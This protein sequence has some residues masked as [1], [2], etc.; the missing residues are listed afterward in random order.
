[1]MLLA[2]RF[3]LCLSLQNTVSLPAPVP[4]PTFTPD[5]PKAPITELKDV[6]VPDDKKTDSKGGLT[7]WLCLIY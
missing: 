6:Q 1:M 4:I 2:L 5:V 7:E 3:G